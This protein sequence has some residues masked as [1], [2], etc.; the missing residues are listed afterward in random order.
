[1]T[2][3][4]NKINRSELL[5]CVWWTVFR[6]VEPFALRP[7]QGLSLPPGLHV[8][9]AHRCS[10]IVSRPHRK[11]PSLIC[12]GQGARMWASSHGRATGP[13]LQRIASLSPAFLFT[14]LAPIQV[15][16]A[17]SGQPRP[18]FSFLEATSCSHCS[19]WWKWPSLETRRAK[20]ST[21]LLCIISRPLLPKCHFLNLPQLWKHTRTH[22]NNNTGNRET[23]SYMPVFIHPIEKCVEHNYTDIVRKKNTENIFQTRLY[24]FEQVSR[25]PYNDRSPYMC[26]LQ[27]RLCGKQEPDSLCTSRGADCFLDC[28]LPTDKVGKKKKPT[29][30]QETTTKLC[31][32]MWQIYSKIDG[33]IYFKPPEQFSQTGVPDT[34]RHINNRKYTRNINNIAILSYTRIR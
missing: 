16:S 10:S 11:F 21:W 13:M 5:H 17:S 2:S 22:R 28:T 30:W 29:K 6:R 9:S 14:L 20:P 23:V 34:W 31:N 25:K 8:T 7:R 32:F 18:A 4:E 3:S 12:V 26:S 19:C 33:Q 1:M 27:S 24:I 15:A